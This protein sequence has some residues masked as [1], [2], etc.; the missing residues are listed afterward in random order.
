MRKIFGTFNPTDA[1]CTNLDSEEAY[2]DTE[3]FIEDRYEVSL[4]HDLRIDCMVEQK[5]FVKSGSES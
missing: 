2:K 1:N 3:E 5:A 4:Q